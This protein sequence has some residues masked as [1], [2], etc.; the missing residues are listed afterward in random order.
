MPKYTLLEMTQ[1]ILSDMNSDEV[2]SVTDTV[3]ALQVTQIIKD[4]FYEIITEGEWPHLKT[5]MQLTASADAGKPTHMRMPENVQKVVSI[6]YNKRSVT[7]TKDEYAQV[8][9]KEPDDFLEHI[10][11]RLSSESTV[12]TI[13]DYSGVPLLIENDLAPTYWTSFDNEWIVF[14]SYDSGVDTTLQSNKTQCVALR[15]PTFTV[16]DTFVPDLPAVAFPYLLSE[17]KSAAF[18]ALKN[19]ANQK[20]EQRASRQRR[21]M[22]QERWRVGGGIT[23][24]DYGRKR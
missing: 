3:E 24:P 12:D 19:T 7:D 16:S 21:R 8:E 2:N 15:E 6:R 20:E 5:L 1:S 17:A 14:D 9:Y 11:K 13:T 18:L 4:T 22:S 23:F 10:M